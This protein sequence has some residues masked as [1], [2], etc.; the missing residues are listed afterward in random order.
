MIPDLEYH[1]QDFV[2]LLQGAGVNW[3]LCA[4]LYIVVRHLRRGK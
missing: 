1:H 2:E 3:L 4:L